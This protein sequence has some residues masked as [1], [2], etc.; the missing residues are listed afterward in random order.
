[1]RHLTPLR[2]VEAVTRHGSIRKAAAALAIA[3]SAL[4]RRILAMEDELGAA[5]FERIAS[6]VRLSAAGEILLEHIRNQ[7]SDMERVRSRVAD[8]SGMRRG[9]VRIAASGEAVV[10]FLPQQIAS[11]RA[12][13]VGVT[14]QVVGL[15]R[16]QVEAALVNHD[17]DIGFVFE[18]LRLADFQP[19]ISL[20]QQPVA[21]VSKDHPLAMREEVRLYECASYPLV[22][23]DRSFGIRHMIENAATRINLEL[24]VSV[25]ANHLEFLNAS[26]GGANYVMI[27]AA[28]GLPSDLDRQRLTT[29]P[30]SAKDVA[31]GFLFAGHLRGRALPVAAARFL[32]QAASDLANGSYY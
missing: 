19:V 32:E 27:A 10:Q 29:R 26:A 31:A 30:I 8:L 14:F 6:G 3:P 5:I 21:V 11:Y 22:L 20:S 15:P 18:P 25:E 24:D 9:N 7:L 28:I 12:Q 1:M 23:P 16:G 13:H 4:N 2:Y 17:A